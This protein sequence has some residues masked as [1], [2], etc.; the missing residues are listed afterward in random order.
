[1]NTAS[2]QLGNFMDLFP[3]TSYRQIQ[4]VGELL[5]MLLEVQEGQYKQPE[6]I[7]ERLTQA[8]N[9]VIDVAERGSFDPWCWAALYVG[10]AIENE[11]SARAGRGEL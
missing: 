4:I 2:K 6:L 5:T 7:H 9:E 3:T 1:M 10:T 8:A 11:V